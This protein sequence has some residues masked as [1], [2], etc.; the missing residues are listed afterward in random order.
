MPIMAKIAGM[1]GFK[2]RAK[3]TCK[4]AAGTVGPYSDPSRISFW[5]ADA[6]VWPAAGPVVRVFASGDTLAHALR[7]LAD[8]IEAKPA[9]EESR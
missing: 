5:F 7:R 4:V 1:L 8:K 2:D 9:P 6:D 3:V